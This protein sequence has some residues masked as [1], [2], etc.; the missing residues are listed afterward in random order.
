MRKSKPFTS[1]IKNQQGV[2]AVVVA[3]ALVA[4][5]GF[6]A[7]AI[8]VGYLY[9][10]RNELQNIAD[11]AALAAT[12]QLGA[13]YQAL[14]YQDQQTYVCNPATIVPVA[15]SVAL[16]NQAAQK[17]IDINADDVV[18][19]KWDG[20]TLTPTLN[21]PDAV[22]VIARRD[23]STLSKSVTTFFASIFSNLDTVD[24]SADAIAAL[25]GKGE[26]EVTELELP[27]GID[28]DWF[29]NE[30]MN[31]YP[32]G[33]CGKLIKF[34]P[35]VDPEACAGWTSWTF[36]SN[37]A[38]LRNILEET[39]QSPSLG[40]GD[41]SNYI[42]GDLSVPTFDDLLN[43][44]KEKGYDIHTDALNADGTLINPGDPPKP[45]QGDI[46]NPTKGALPT[47][48][49]NVFNLKD[50]DGT[51]P[52]VYPDGTTERNAHVW[53][54]TVLVYKSQNCANPNQS[55]AIQGYATILLTDILGPP[56]KLVRGTILCNYTTPSN[57]RGGGGKYGTL[58]PIPG[59]VE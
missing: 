42:G 15:Q 24:I 4:L 23:S 17:Y 13:I 9:A 25:T 6:A 14:S 50:S 39:L 1:V 5:L 20:S 57:T 56:D 29:G 45:A 2:S 35:T 28:E 27:I 40:V 33:F 48:D 53:I 52:L 55:I 16:K 43:L 11:A 36:G 38:N 22:G 21:Q 32:A 19:G 37:D 18:I 30:P 59:L 44:F 31:P 54:T 7:L 58:G 41:L 47:S 46:D 49:P 3:I 34:S 51:T 12:R 26:S 10:T 8:D